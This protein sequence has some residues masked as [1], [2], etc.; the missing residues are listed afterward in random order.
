L[1]YA[2]RCS[3]LCVPRVDDKD[4]SGLGE[5]FHAVGERF[6]IYVV[7]LDPLESLLSE[8]AK[9]AGDPFG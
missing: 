7:N 3:V 8:L 1:L 2:I 5:A 9:A 4:I 6:V